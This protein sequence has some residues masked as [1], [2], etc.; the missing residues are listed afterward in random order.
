[1]IVQSI[2]SSNFMSGAFKIWTGKTVNILT[3][4]MMSSARGHQNLFV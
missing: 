4:I 3:G 2:T 1:M